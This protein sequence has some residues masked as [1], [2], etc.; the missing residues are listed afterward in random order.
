LDEEIMAITDPM[1]TIVHLGTLEIPITKL[2]RDGAAGLTPDW[3]QGHNLALLILNKDEGPVELLNAAGAFQRNEA[4]SYQRF[5]KAVMDLPSERIS[6]S[7]LKARRAEQQTP[8][9]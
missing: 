2:I 9:T 8:S 3:T 5:C 7:A 1:I 4:G 6:Q